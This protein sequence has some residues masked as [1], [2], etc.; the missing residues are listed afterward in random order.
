MSAKPSPAT[1]QETTS[2]SPTESLEWTGERFIPELTGSIAEEHLHRYAIASRLTK[3][4]SV[5]DIASGEG[6]GS[7]ILAKEAKSVTGVE[8]DPASVRHANSKYTIS[9]LKFMVGDALSIPAQ[10]H[11][12]E[13]IV[14]FETIEHVSDHVQF[15]H[16]L[17]RVLKPTGL[18]IIS[19]PEKQHYTDLSGHNN[20]FHVHELYV[21]EF[22]NLLLQQFRNVAILDQR[23]SKGSLILPEDGFDF[24]AILGVSR[25]TASELE[26]TPGV[27]DAIYKLAICSNGPLPSIPCGF[28]EHGPL[29]AKPFPNP[30]FAIEGDRLAEAATRSAEVER[31]KLTHSFLDQQIGKMLNQIDGIFGL[32]VRDSKPAIAILN[33]LFVALVGDMLAFLEAPHLSQRAVGNTLPESSIDQQLSAAASSLEALSN[34]SNQKQ[35]NE[36][37]I[38][39][40]STLCDHPSITKGENETSH[41]PQGKLKKT[42]D[43]MRDRHRK[44]YSFPKRWLPSTFSRQLSI[45]QLGHQALTQLFESLRKYNKS[46]LKASV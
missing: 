5:L 7:A 6:Y 11:E 41:T 42:M 16:E 22:R 33:N 25:G 18:L 40:I 38:S 9:N 2:G 28:F 17:N 15:L 35:W 1:F 30:Y 39:L 45:H 26:F 20:P 3:M 19:S 29:D 44:E 32:T 23:V 8:I 13:A 43:R 31:R 34:S 12:F 10:D 4:M 14:S 21:E 46:Q 36:S 37:L 27:P 24:E